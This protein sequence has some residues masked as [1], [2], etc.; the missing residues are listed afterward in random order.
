MP[1]A[2]ASTPPLPPG[3]PPSPAQQAGMRT[4]VPGTVA[5]PKPEVYGGIKVVSQVDNDAKNDA[6]KKT[7]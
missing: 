3:F 6:K 7:E 5:T 4:A 2:G 1:A